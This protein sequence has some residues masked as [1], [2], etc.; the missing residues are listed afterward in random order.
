[1][2][3]AIVGERERATA[4]EKHLRK[5]STVKEVTITTSLSDSS[6]LDTVLLI[7]DTKDN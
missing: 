2:K 4:W 6:G 7:D 3:I 1:M 5:L